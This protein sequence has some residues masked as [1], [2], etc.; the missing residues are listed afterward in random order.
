MGNGAA[1]AR[2]DVKALDR[3][4]VSGLNITPTRASPWQKRLSQKALFCDGRHVF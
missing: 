1:M 3:G 4:E 2:S